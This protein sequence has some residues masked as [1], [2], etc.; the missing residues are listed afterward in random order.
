[1]NTDDM[2]TRLGQ[3]ARRRDALE[4]EI[5]GL[6]GMLRTEALFA[7]ADPVTSRWEVTWQAIADELGMTRQGAQQLYARRWERSS[8]EARLPQ[9]LR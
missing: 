2:L 3:L 8:A 9:R 1:M 5:D 7:E 6:V 4:H